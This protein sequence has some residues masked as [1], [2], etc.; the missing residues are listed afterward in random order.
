MVNILVGVI[1]QTA[2]VVFPIYLVIR[3]NYMA[4][5]AFGVAAVTTYILKLNWYDK[6]ED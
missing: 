6:L 3:E 1:W 2:L 4:A 5:I